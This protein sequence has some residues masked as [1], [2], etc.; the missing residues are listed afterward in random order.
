MKV[1]RLPACSPV[2]LALA[3]WLVA[4][5]GAST[6]A[7]AL[8]R[9]DAV[10]IADAVNDLEA[11]P[12]FLDST[13]TQQGI[14]VSQVQGQ[15]DIWLASGMGLGQRSWYPDA[16]DMGW[17]RITLDSGDPFE[18]VSM[19][20]GS[21]WLGPP[22]A[23]YYQLQSGGALV[24]SGSFEASFAGEWFT[25][26]GGDFDSVLLRAYMAPVESLSGCVPLVSPEGHTGQCNYF[27]VDQI[28]IGALDLTGDPG[29]GR[30]PLPGTLALTACGLLAA[31]RRRETA[32]A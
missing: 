16:G 28:K 11:A 13:W 21:A 10:P 17:T 2:H 14:R 1:P 20:G 7:A 27:W 8:H 22:Q 23:I 26:S 9:F 12:A 25:F 3:A 29:G 31:W 15:N 30:V 24:A 18:A 19:F 5:P 4:S 32:R 6:H